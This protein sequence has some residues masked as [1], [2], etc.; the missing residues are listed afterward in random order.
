MLPVLRARL[1][2]L[3]EGEWAPYREDAGAEL[4]CAEV[5]DYDGAPEGLADR[6][7]RWLAIRAPAPDSARPHAP[8]HRRLPRLRPSF[9]IS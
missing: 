6:P 9:A 4:E 5:S 2:E 8:V 1:E 3:P 7:L